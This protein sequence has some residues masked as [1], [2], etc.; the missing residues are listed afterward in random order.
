MT[1]QSD[2]RGKVA[3]RN[4]ASILGHWRF[5]D[6]ER[7]RYGGSAIGEEWPWGLCVSNIRFIEGQVWATARQD[8]GPIDARIILGYRSLEHEYFV[9]GLGGYGNAYTV[10]HFI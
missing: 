2:H 3:V 9:I 10:T 1:N 7:I 6:G 5:E 8:D 4:W